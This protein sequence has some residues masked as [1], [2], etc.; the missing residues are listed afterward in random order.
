MSPI[1]TPVPISWEDIEGGLGEGIKQEIANFIYEYC[2]ADDEGAPRYWDSDE[3]LPTDLAF[4][5]EAWDKIDGNRDE[6]ANPVQTSAV[7]SLIKGAFFHSTA[8]DKIAEALMKSATKPQLIEIITHVANAYCQYIA[9]RAR[10]EIAEAKADGKIVR[11]LREFA[12]CQLETRRIRP[13]GCRSRKR[14]D[15]GGGMRN[16]P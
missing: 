13:F 14:R 9:L 12:V 5:E 15:S 1:F 7:L 4:F 16:G 10:V 11:E 2:Y 6:I 3:E 8:R